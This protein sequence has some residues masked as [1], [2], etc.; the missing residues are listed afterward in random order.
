MFGI[1]VVKVVV[2]DV[3]CVFGYFYGFVDRILKLILLDLG[4]MFE[5]VFKVELQLLEVYE[6]DEEVKDF[7]DMV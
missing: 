7:I 3:G 5:K 6:S 2:C 4:M 1:M